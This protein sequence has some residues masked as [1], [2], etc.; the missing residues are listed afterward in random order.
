MKLLG[1]LVICIS[2]GLSFKV[3]A[4]T[5]CPQFAGYR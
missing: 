4:Q 2:S 5:A 1:V 3:V